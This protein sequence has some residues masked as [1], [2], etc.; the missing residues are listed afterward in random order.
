MLYVHSYN[1]ARLEAN[2][3]VPY[4][5]RQGF[6]VAVIELQRFTYNSTRG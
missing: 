5:L 4:L 6:N 1:S 2:S 3:V